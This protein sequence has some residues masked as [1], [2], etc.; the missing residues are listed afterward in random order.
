MLQAGDIFQCIFG[1]AAKPS[2]ASPPLPAPPHPAPPR[3][4]P[5]ANT[6]R[7]MWN[8]AGT[9]LLALTASDVDAT[10]QSYY[11]E[12]ARCARFGLCLVHTVPLAFSQRQAMVH[13]ISIVHCPFCESVG[14]CA[15][16][17]LAGPTQGIHG[18]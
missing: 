7:L 10:N 14:T 5:Q 18:S 2:L 13:A 15:P 12:R 1:P 8:A 9:A 16:R 3:P 6:A 17:Y 4:A 11:G